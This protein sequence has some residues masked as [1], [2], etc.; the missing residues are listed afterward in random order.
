MKER[1]THATIAG[2]RYLALRKRA[3]ALGRPT[4]ELLQLSALEGFLSRLERS[5]HRR[6]LVLKG[7]M[8][9]AAFDLRRPTRDI[10]FLAI[11]VDN[12]PHA[13]GRLI[14]EVA[15]VDLDDGLEFIVGTLDTSRIR[16]D[17]VYPGVR[18]RLEV[19]LATARLRLQVDVNVGDPVVPGAQLIEIPTLFPGSGPV[20]LAYPRAMVIAE[21]LVTALQ[22]GAASTRWRDF[23]DLYLMIAA[24]PGDEEQMASCIAV[25]SKHR[26]V[27]L[28]PLRDVLEGMPERAQPRWASW[29]RQQ[30]LEGRV[31]R[32]FEQLLDQLDQATWPWIKAAIPTGSNSEGAG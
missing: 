29:L 24:V 30:G 25:V 16:D 17:D 26:G 12:E 21:K 8:L 5:E 15:A 27:P 6:R 22:R 9:L 13:V 2:A 3:K 1:P 23:S 14:A 32:S 19:L 18:V 20:V 7:G 31:P 11:E 4:A 28:V 10:D